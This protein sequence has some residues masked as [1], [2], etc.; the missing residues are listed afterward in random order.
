MKMVTRR[1]SQPSRT[2]RKAKAARYVVTATFKK[3]ISIPLSKSIADKLAK[4]VRKNGGTAIIK[5]A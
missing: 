2:K 3:M 5:K 1:K 4:D